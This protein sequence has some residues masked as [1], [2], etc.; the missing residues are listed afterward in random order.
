MDTD[1]KVPEDFFSQFAGDLDM[2][3][4]VDQVRSAPR[5]DLVDHRELS[6]IAIGQAG[7][8]RGDDVIELGIRKKNETPG[9]LGF[10]FLTRD[11][12]NTLKEAGDTL[13]RKM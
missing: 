12:W 4:Y 1:A 6:V 3:Q 8:A 9:I 2:S 10:L 11:Q 7:K 13:F 5:L